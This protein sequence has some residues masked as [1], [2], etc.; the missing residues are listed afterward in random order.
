MN[1]NKK[2][3]VLAVLIGESIDL[4]YYT[5]GGMNSVEVVRVVEVSKDYTTLAKPIPAASQEPDGPLEITFSVIIDRISELSFH[6]N[7][8]A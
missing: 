5:S 2:R 8:K 6:S 3:A 7:F 1:K 4:T